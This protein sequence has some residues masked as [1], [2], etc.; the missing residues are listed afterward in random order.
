M[1]CTKLRENPEVNYK[2]R[3]IIMCPCRFINGNKYTTLVGDADSRVGCMC[4]GQRA[5]G[6]SLYLLVNLAVNLK[7]L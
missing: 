2:L 1:E 6:K 7:L 4:I 3:V 5:C